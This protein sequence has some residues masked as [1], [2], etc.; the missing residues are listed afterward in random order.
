MPLLQSC[1][2]RAVGTFPEV[3][4][5]AAL[6]LAPEP[7][8]RGP[9]DRLL[10][11]GARELVRELVRQGASCSE[12]ER[13]ERAGGDAEDVGDLLV[14][15]TFELSQDDRLP[16]Y[17]PVAGERPMIERQPGRSGVNAALAHTTGRREVLG[18]LVA[19]IV[20]R[21]L[22]AAPV[23]GHFRAAGIDRDELAIDAGRAGLGQ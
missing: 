7:S 17:R 20:F 10:R 23:G 18:A 12:E 3:F 4:L 6:L 22:Q 5:Q 2:L 16:L 15:A 8:V 11:L 14:R 21:R 9:R 13:L 19:Q 1:E